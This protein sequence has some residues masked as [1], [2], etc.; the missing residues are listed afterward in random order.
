MKYS[1]HK[2]QIQDCIYIIIIVFDAVTIVY[3]VFCSFSWQSQLMPLSRLPHKLV[4]HDD[5]L[6]RMV[7]MMMILLVVMMA[8]VTKMMLFVC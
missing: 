7:L 3:V 8:A 6:M 4:T 1:V 2:V 5:I